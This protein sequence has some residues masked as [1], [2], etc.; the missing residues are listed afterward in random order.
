MNR[1]NESS[2]KESDGWECF[3]GHFEMSEF[4]CSNCG[5]QP[6]WGCNCFQCTKIE[7]ELDEKW[8]NYIFKNERGR[9]NRKHGQI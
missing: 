3:C 7:Q 6:C 9:L 5:R 1:M 2:D 8:N 4:H